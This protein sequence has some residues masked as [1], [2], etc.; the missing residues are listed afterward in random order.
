MS[1]AKDSYVAIAASATAT[2][3]G[4]GVLGNYLKRIIVSVATS[5]TSSVLL[6]DS[7]GATAI[8]LVPSNTP[9]G[10]YS[11]DLDIR[12]V[13]TTTTVGFHVTTAAGVSVVC[14]GHFGTQV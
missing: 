11:I 3:L 4:S 1:V 14:V 6:Y 12:A 5:A 7:S 8:P 9:I 13:G 10:V 2:K